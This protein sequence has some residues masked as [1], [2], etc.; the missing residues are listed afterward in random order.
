MVPLSFG[1]EIAVSGYWCLD[2]ES[3]DNSI[4]FLD[5]ESAQPRAHSHILDHIVKRALQRLHLK[6]TGEINESSFLKPEEGR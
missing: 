5:T 1:P 2:T 6:A 3:L 4:Q